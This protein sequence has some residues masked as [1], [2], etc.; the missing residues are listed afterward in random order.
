MSQEIKT[1]HTRDEFIQA[2]VDQ[3]H[4]VEEGKSI[5]ELWNILD[6]VFRGISKEERKAL[7]KEI[8]GLMVKWNFQHDGKFE[9]NPYADLFHYLDTSTSR[10]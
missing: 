10:Y 8:G 4:E 5:A 2:L 9:G 1:E 7:S 6:P 3:Y